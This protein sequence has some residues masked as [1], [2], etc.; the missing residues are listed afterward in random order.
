MLYA[1][2][3]TAQDVFQPIPGPHAHLLSNMCTCNLHVVKA[4]AFGGN[5]GNK[6][7]NFELVTENHAIA[8]VC[9]M[10]SQ[11]GSSIFMFGCVS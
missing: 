5:F 2:S 7:F 11:L 9:W 8:N 6:F 4:K 10:R 3:P 1:K